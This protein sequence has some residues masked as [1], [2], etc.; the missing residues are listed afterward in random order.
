GLTQQLHGSSGAEA[1]RRLSA[2]RENLLAV[3]DY[4]LA[5]R[6]ATPESLA[7]ALGG[8]IALEPDVTG[9]GP[10]DL[11]LERLDQ[12][13][14]LAAS[15]PVDPL[16]SAEALAVRGRAH[17][18]LGRLT[19]ARKDLEEARK[20]FYGLGEGAL[21]KRVLVELSTVARH[22]GDM[23]TAWALVVGARALP[24]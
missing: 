6:P 5:E 21:E 13:L 7:R 19:A 1:L 22:G 24:S 16:L 11:T 2:E 20:S 18:E 9:R 3:C 4:A 10:M 17:L 12:A 14:E 23:N 15:I 8:L